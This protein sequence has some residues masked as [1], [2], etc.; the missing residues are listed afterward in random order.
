[1]E[2]KALNGFSLTWVCLCLPQVKFVVKWKI[3]WLE[4]KKI[5]VVVDIDL[6]IMIVDCG[7]SLW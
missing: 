1:M 3:V 2:F 5:G 6:P 4:K 7:S